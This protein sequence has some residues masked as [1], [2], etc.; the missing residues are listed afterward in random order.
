MPETV[1][2]TVTG[3]CPIVGTDGKDVPHGGTVELDPEQ[4]N[5]PALIEGG[6]V[7]LA[8]KAAAKTLKAGEVS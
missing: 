7:E 5:I 1:K 6:H 4:T 3:P 8:T 2:C